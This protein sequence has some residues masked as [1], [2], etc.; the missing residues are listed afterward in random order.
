[1]NVG[2]INRAVRADV[3]IPK[4]RMNVAVTVD[5]PL[6]LMAEHVMVDINKFLIFHSPFTYS[7]VIYDDKIK[8]NK[9]K[10]YI[11]MRMFLDANEC[12]MQNGGCE[13]ICINTRGS[14]FCGCHY[15]YQLASDGRSC[16]GMY[17]YV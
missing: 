3:L 13:Q 11:G 12:L 14:Y 16:Y 17:E 10:V 15:G 4:D 5:T 1:M 9:N 2:I 8:S 7:L 6:M